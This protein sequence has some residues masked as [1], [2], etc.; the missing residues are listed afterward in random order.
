MPASDRSDSIL[1]NWAYFVL[2]RAPAAH[3][4]QIGLLLPL[5]CLTAAKLLDMT[6]LHLQHFR[7]GA[8][9]II[10]T[11]ALSWSYPEGSDAGHYPTASLHIWN[12]PKQRWIQNTCLL[13]KE[14]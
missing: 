10:D 2:F 11:N 12:R 1:V 6:F 4:C 7:S 14:S 3:F 5:F 8:I 13:H 9:P